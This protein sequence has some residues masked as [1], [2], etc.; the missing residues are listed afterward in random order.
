MTR[1]KLLGA[2]AA[3]AALMAFA[4]WAGSPYEPVVAPAAEIEA[5]WAVEDTRMESEAPLVSL[6]HNHGRPLGYDAESNTFYCPVAL[7]QG[8]EWPDIHLT[9]AC[10]PDVRLM[11]VDD[12]AYD[13]CSDAVANGYSYEVMAYTDTEYAYFNIVFTGMMQIHLQ[14]AGEFSE[15]Y[16][17]VEAVFSTD[18]AAVSTHGAAHYRGGVT[19]HAEK[20][21]YRL[22]FTKNTDGTDRVALEVPGFGRVENLNLVPMMMDAT[23][24][25][26]HLAWDLYGLTHTDK[27]CYGVRKMAYAEVFVNDRY[28]GLYLVMEPFDH[29]AELEKHAAGAAAI[30]CVYRTGRVVDDKDR[31]CKLGG[32]LEE[33]GYEL[34]YEPAGSKQFAAVDSFIDLCTE[35]SDEVFAERF[36]SVVDVDSMIDYFLHLQAYCMIDNVFNNMFTIAHYENGA[37]KV[38]F[39]PWDMD[40]TMG[41]PGHPY[42]MWVY[43]PPMDRA[44]DLDVDG[45]REKVLEAWRVLRQNTLTAENVE[46][47][48]NGYMHEVNDSG[49][50][51]R[52]AA[53]WNKKDEYLDGY[54]IMSFAADRFSMLDRVF[55]QIAQTEGRLEMLTYSDHEYKYG[56]IYGLE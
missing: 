20:K 10:N 3:L 36:S 38:S 22:K 32:M 56:L 17:P 33:Y 50:A 54:G 6:L 26:D 16:I 49:A 27:D 53:R 4:V 5:V 52:D 40:M 19:M 23:R 25:R 29:A 55:E 34:H 51:A 47:L 12:Y 39:A 1:L 30:D 41:T 14:A 42:D 48:L 24:M 7:D 45:I 9:A 44:I 37:Y 28:N 35:E 31:P 11:F 8:E 15:Q 43:F 2:M 13:F 18:S 21:A 46:I